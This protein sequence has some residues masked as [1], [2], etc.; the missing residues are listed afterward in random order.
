MEEEEVVRLNSVANLQQ[1]RK[2]PSQTTKNV[3]RLGLKIKWCPFKGCN[4]ATH[5]LRH[6]NGEALENYLRIAREYKG[7][8]EQEEVEHSLALNRKWSAVKDDSGLEPPLKISKGNKDDAEADIIEQD[9][10]HDNFEDSSENELQ[11]GILLPRNDCHKWLIGF[12][13]YLHYPDCRRK[14]KRNRLQHAGN[15]KTILQELEPSCTGM[16][17]LVEEE[18]YIVWTQWVDCNMGPRSFC[19][20]NAYLGTFEK[21]LVFVTADTVRPGI[22]PMLS[23]DVKK[24]L[25]KTKARLKGWRRTVHLNG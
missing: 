11:L 24:I 4:F 16:D 13:N 6:Q 22:L 9:I 15:I 17:T 18:G 5:I 23:E 14:K 21:F 10:D 8:L 2:G 20:I 7:K 3:P 19:T 12:S 25:R 1:R